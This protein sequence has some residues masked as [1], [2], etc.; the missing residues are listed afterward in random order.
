MSSGPDLYLV[1]SDGLTS[2]VPE[3]RVGE[4]LGSSESLGAAGRALI[5]A[6]N[7]AGGRD[8]ITVVLFRQKDVDAGTLNGLAWTCAIG[9]VHLAQARLA[10]ERAVALEPKNTEILDTLA[11]VHYRS[12]NAAKAIEVET[13]ALSLAPQ[14]QYLKDQI[15]RFTSGTK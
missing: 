9:G 1:C 3:A 4:I 7:E 14:D 8:N 2:M 15:A 11:E 6:A 10:A 13:Q 12:G 5:D